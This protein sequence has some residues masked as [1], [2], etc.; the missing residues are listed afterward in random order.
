MTSSLCIGTAQF[1]FKYGVTNKDGIVSIEEVQKIIDMAYDSGVK[2]I[3]T[4]QAYGK[5]EEILGKTIRDNQ[6]FKII[7]KISSPNKIKSGLELINE[8]EVKFEQ[9]L[10]NL[11]KNSIDTLLIHNSQDLRSAH[12][13][14]ILMWL[15]NLKINKLVKRIGISVYSFDEIDDVKL[16]DF[17][18]IQIPLSI[19]DQRLLNRGYLKKI[20]SSDCKIHIRSIFLQGLVLA[21]TSNLPNFLSEEFKN[22][23]KKFSNFAKI[24]K[25]SKLNLA[26]SFIKS[27]NNVEATLIGVDNLVQFSQII[28]IWNKNDLNSINKNLFDFSWDKIQDVDPRYWN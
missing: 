27:L 4:A 16:S 9:S 25:I 1:G 18:V 23:H 28:S 24:N 20:I 19:F 8:L 26:C 12:G 17:D 5:S 6:N 11:K 13:K 2:Y 7:S 15:K 3:D 10:Q 14:D 22:H 21:K